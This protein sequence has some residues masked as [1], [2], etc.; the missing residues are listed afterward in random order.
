MVLM[1]YKHILFILSR[2]YKAKMLIKYKLYDPHLKPSVKSYLWWLN[3]T[4]KTSDLMTFT[5]L[6]L[7]RSSFSS[8]SNYTSNSLCPSFI[9]SNS[10][11]L[12]LRLSIS[13]LSSI[14]SPYRAR[15]L[16][17]CSM[18]LSLGRSGCTLLS[19]CSWAKM[20]AVPWGRSS[21]R[22]FRGYGSAGK[23]FSCSYLPITT[24]QSPWGFC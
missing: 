16:R 22:S 11:H 1:L 17:C 8:S 21:S 5:T 12:I 20:T 13:A 15:I 3:Q 14:L 18:A 10:S 23:G 19:C 7:P 2:S 24:I 6:P 9:A 4:L